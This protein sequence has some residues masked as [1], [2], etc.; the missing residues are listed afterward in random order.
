VKLRD[1]GRLKYI[2]NLSLIIYKKR[3]NKHANRMGEDTW[4]KKTWYICLRRHCELQKTRKNTAK[5]ILK[6]VQELR[7]PFRESRRTRFHLRQYCL[8]LETYK[9]SN[10]M[11]RLQYMCSQLNIKEAA[12]NILA[13]LYKT[14]YSFNIYLQI[15]WNKNYTNYVTKGL[16]R[17]TLWTSTRKL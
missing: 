10:L 8:L 6:S 9:C 14:Q 2:I 15:Q 3:Q 11:I 7:F 16:K 13:I 12:V 5:N 17:K 1:S 4:L